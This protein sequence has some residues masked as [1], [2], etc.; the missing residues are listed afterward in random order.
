[1]N[2]ISGYKAAIT[3][4]ILVSGAVLCGTAW[5]DTSVWEVRSDSNSVYLGGTVHLLR[6]TDYP[7]P[8]EFEQAYQASSE[9]YLETDIGSM[10]DLSVQAQLLQQLTYQD[11]RSLKTVLSNEAYTALSDYTEQIGMPLMIMEKFKP[12]MVVSTLQILEFQRVGFTPQGVDMYFNTRAM[13]D[14][15]TLGQLETVQEQIG[16]LAAMGEGNESEFILLSLKDLAE[17]NAV[18]EDMIRAWRTG[19]NASLADLFVT[20][21]RT[22]TPD[23][24]D[25]LLRQ[26]NLRWIPQIE[27]MLRDSDTEFVLVGAAHLVGED[28]L[29]QLLQAKG[30]QIRQL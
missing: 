2:E 29:L 10:T 24:Y 13:G 9:I 28:G 21:M 15:K 17:T 19:D 3:A 4:I 23:L 12:G 5:A 14:A 26:R 6:P 1:M 27:Q 7:L 25:S 22:E 30:Y 11:E 20:E 16:F 18:M 8:E